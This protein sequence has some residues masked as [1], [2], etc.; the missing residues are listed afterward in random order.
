MDTS[1]RSRRRAG[2]AAARLALV[3]ALVA[4]PALAGEDAKLELR[5][6]DEQVQEVKSEVLSIATELDQ[7]EERLLYPSNTQLAVF[8]SFAPG[9]DFRLDSVQIHIDGEPVARHVYSFKELEA[10]QKGGVQRIYTGN[11]TAGEHRVD[12][13]IAGK[14]A[15]GEDFSGSESIAFSKGVPPKLLE[16]TL[17]GGPGVAAIRLADG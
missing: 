12:V 7:L 15:R 2:S 9:E 4:P 5:S 13:S 14:T 10:L 3:S 8:V 1:V 6:L 16:I 11:V 17:G